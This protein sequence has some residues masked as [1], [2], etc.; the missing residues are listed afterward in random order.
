MK[1]TIISLKDVWKTYKMG[2]VYVN[3]LQGLNFKINEG[4][5]VAIQGPSGSGKSTAMHLIG[6]LDIPTKGV[7]MLEGKNIAKMSES[8][9]AQIRGRIIGFVFQTFNLINT[10][11]SLENVMLPMTFQKIPKE[12]R[13]HRAEKLLSL[14]GLA[15][16]MNHKPNELSGGEQQ[17]VAIARALANNPDVILAD[18]PTGDLD[19]KT[20]KMIVEL[21]KKLNKEEGKTV[22]MVTHDESIAKLAQRIDYL[23]DGKII[24]SIKRWK[25]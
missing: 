4:E 19:S 9:L 13:K 15:G 24:K 7:I 21:L 8:E 5:F 12:E 2:E 23:K 6:C 10:L 17:R 1:K 20:G 14:V 25:K 16:R 22:I 11:T 3:A 18:E